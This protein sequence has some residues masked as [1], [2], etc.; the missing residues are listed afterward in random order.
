M[1]RTILGFVRKE[2]TQ[3]M[4]DPR[5]K[6]LLFIMPVVQMTLFGIALSNEVK[7]IRLAAFLDPQDT[8]L[9]D[10][11]ERAIAGGWFVPARTSGGDPFELIRANKADAVLV[12]PPGGFTRALGRGRA[13][14]QLL[15]DATNV[16][17][18][19]SVEGYLAR[20]VERTVE[21]D[22]KI[23]PPS[24]PIRFDVR[25]LFNPSLNT[26]IFMVPGVMV[27]VMLLMTMVLTMISIVREKE[28]GTFEALISAPVSRSEVIFGK[29]L[30]YV[31]IGMTNLPLI[32]GVAVLVFRVPMRGNL[33]VL[34]GAALAFVCTTVA[35]GTL[36]STFCANQQQANMA[37]FL[38]NFP[39]I[40]FSGIIFPIENMPA[41]IRWLSY[42]DPL[43]HFLGLIRNIMLK[44]GD[45]RYIAVH[46]GALIA[47]ALV[48]V[49][50][51][52]RR[53]HTTLS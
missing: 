38:F 23:A 36:I 3:A 6:V 45:A 18:A 32:V 46:V 7:N 21:D 10:V 35:V 17:Q 47:M 25:V 22:L 9:R 26:T 49:S 13:P 43:A 19:Q 33:L 44:G 4:R 29:T 14:L 39:A 24:P 34:A 53:F 27:M 2:L 16:V 12:A 31:L 41:G 42:I 1:N 48:S 51:S 28:L 5:M 40:M 50:V 20:I 52:F 37:G 8:V 15:V 30:P 11:Y